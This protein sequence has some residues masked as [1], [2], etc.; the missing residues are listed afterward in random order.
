[1]ND[2]YLLCRCSKDAVFLL[3]FCYWEGEGGILGQDRRKRRYCA[4]KAIFPSY[5]SIHIT[6]CNVGD[7]ECGF[8]IVENAS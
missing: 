5:L 7:G 3:Y 2:A 6:A 4:T 1:M 8:S